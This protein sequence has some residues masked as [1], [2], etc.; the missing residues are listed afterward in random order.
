M[1]ALCFGGNQVINVEYK[2][3][4]GAAA[5]RFKIQ[6]HPTGVSDEMVIW[7]GQTINRRYTYFDYC[8]IFWNFSFE[9]LTDT[10]FVSIVMTWAPFIPD[11]PG[12]RP[13]DF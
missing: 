13:K 7:A 12:F 9:A 3:S 5:N 2:G 10:C 4:F 1:C 6:C 11:C 8:P